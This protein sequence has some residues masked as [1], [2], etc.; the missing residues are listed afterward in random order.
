MEVRVSEF[1]GDAVSLQKFVQ[2][3]LQVL[4]DGKWF[5][6]DL[7]TE[8]VALLPN[9]RCR[10][11]IGVDAKKFTK[12]DLERLEGKIGILTLS[13]NGYKIPFRL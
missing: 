6:T 2:S 11:W 1:V 8:A 13:A 5:P 3:T 4:F 12:A 10:A 7:A 9:Q